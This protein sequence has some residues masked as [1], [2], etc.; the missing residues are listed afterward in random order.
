MINGLRITL[1]GSEL[2][3]RIA[4]RIRMHE[5]TIGA[6][7]ERIKQREGDLPFDV[8]AEDGF[9]TLG[10]LETE[11]QHYRDRVC[12]LTLLR[13]NVTREE[14]YVLDKRD[15]LLAELISTG[16]AEAHEPSDEGAV[17]RDHGMSVPIDGLKLTM[18]GVEIRKR[19]EQRIDEHHRRADRWKREGARTP[20]QQT[21]DEPLLPDDLCANE[22]ERHEWRVDV[23][24][25]MREHV[26]LAEVYRLAEA[27]LAFGELLP[28]K[29]GWLEHEEYEERNRVGF[30][31]ERLTKGVGAV[32]PASLR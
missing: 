25:F 20:D 32:L 5:A 10:E 23:L 21:E 12:C 8:R 15:M 29:P 22:A 3:D 7:D 28:A 31:L 19:L 16:S 4:E 1:Q 30:Q 18:S 11:R 27:D 13:N 17:L 6:L 2:S 14:M 9:K 24:T 26:A